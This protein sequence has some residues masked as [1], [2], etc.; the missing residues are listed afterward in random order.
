M[1]LLANAHCR[2]VSRDANGRECGLYP[3]QF[4]VLAV[5]SH[6]GK[7]FRTRI[8]QIITSG[9]GKMK[10]ITSVSGAAADDVAAYVHTL[11]K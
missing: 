11:K 8:K 10:P 7:K 3:D 9:K 5:M 2:H 6:V 1:R 4:E